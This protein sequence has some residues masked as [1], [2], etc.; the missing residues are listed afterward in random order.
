MSQS[1]YQTL[2][3]GLVN[4]KIDHNPIKTLLQQPDAKCFDEQ[5]KTEK[6]CL[7]QRYQFDKGFTGDSLSKECT[8]AH[9]DIQSFGCLHD[10]GEESKS[11]KSDRSANSKL[12]KMKIV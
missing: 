9:K 2:A 4:Q 5:S 12:L 8:T 7:G 3:V 6:D 1:E 10:K 11:M